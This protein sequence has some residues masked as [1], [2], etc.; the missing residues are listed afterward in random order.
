MSD[1]MEE[2][3]AWLASS[4]LAA[5]VDSCD[6]AI[7]GMTLDGTVTSW[8]KAAEQIFGYSAQETIGR[9]ISILIPPDL[10]DEEPRMLERVSQGERVEHYESVRRRKDGTLVDV[11]LTISPIRD[12]QGNII[13]IS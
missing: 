7:I 8:N 1:P 12:P 2:R 13:G 10:E 6:D 11:S 3:S 5:I 9:D 4:R